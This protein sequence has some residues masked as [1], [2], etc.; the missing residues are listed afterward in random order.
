MIEASKPGKV[1]ISREPS[2]RSSWRRQGAGVCAD[3][4]ST[5]RAVTAGSLKK[6]GWGKAATCARADDFDFRFGK[7][8]RMGRAGVSFFF[9][10][11]VLGVERL[12]GGLFFNLDGSTFRT[13]WMSEGG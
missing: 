4:E 10:A 1:T 11:A 9:G 13:R 5:G 8:G 2:A 3:E 12:A 7:P 6:A